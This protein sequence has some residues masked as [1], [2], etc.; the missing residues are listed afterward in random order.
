MSERI[1]PIQLRAY[2]D[3]QREHKGKPRPKLVNQ[4]LILDNETTT[5]TQRL[6]FGSAL[7]RTVQQ[8]D[9]GTIYRCFTVREVFYYADDLET[10]RPR[11]FKA[12]QRYVENHGAAI[13]Y[14]PPGQEWPTYEDQQHGRLDIET[15]D[16]I[17]LV[18]ESQ[19]RDSYILHSAHSDIPNDTRLWEPA[20]IVGANVSF[21]IWRH[22]NRVMPARGMFYGGL[23][24][25]LSDRV[26]YSEIRSGIGM[27]RRLTLSGQR[28]DSKRDVDAA[29]IVDVLQLTRA[30]TGQAH[31]LLSAGKAMGC[32]TLK[33][34][35][36]E[37]HD[38]EI[39]YHGDDL[40]AQLDHYVAYNRND[41]AATAELYEKV[42]DRFLRHPINLRADLTFSPASISKQY[43]RDMGIHAPLCA[44]PSCRRSNR[45]GHSIGRDVIGRCMTAFYGGKSCIWE[46]LT[47][48]PAALIDWTSM[49]P[50]IMLLCDI[51][52]MLIAEQVIVR[53]ATEAVQEFLDTVT[54]DDLDRPETW[55]KLRGI[56]EFL[57]DEDLG[58]T[59]A[60][61]AAI[62]HKDSESV[63]SATAPGIAVNYLTSDK[64]ITWTIADLVANKL[65]NG[66]KVPRLVN[67]W[68][69]EPSDEIQ[70]T[71]GPIKLSGED[72]LLFDPT[73]DNLLKFQIEERQKAKTRHKVNRDTCGHVW[74]EEDLKRNPAT[75]AVVGIRSCRCP[76]CE[77][78]A[79]AKNM[80]QTGYAEAEYVE[81]FRRESFEAHQFD[82][83]D[84][85]IWNADT[86]KCLCPDCVNASFLKPFSNS[87]Y[88]V[89]AEMNR[90][91]QRQDGKNRT[92]TIHGIDGESWTV[93]NP[94]EP[95]EFCFPPFA[96]VITGGAR[97]MLAMLEH[98]VRELG[99]FLVFCDTDSGCIPASKKGGTGVT[100]LSYAQ[101]DAIRE[102]FNQLNPYDRTIVE[103]LVKWEH[104]KDSNGRPSRNPKDQI[105][106][107]AIS[108]KRYALYSLVNNQ[109]KLIPDGIV[110]LDD[111]ETEFSEASEDD[112][113]SDDYV[114]DDIVKRS[115]HGLGLFMS[116]R[117][118][119]AHNDADVNDPGWYG[120]TWRYIIN[121]HVFHRSVKEP[122]WFSL[123]A[124]SRF[125]VR[126]LHYWRIFDQSFNQDKPIDRQVRPYNFYLA[127]HPVRSEDKVRLIAP[128]SD[129]P[130]TWLSLPWIDANTGRRYDITTDP[131]KEI[132]G[133][134][135]LVKDYRSVV[136]RYVTHPEWKFDAQDGNPCGPFTRGILQPAHVVAESFPHITKDSSS[137]TTAG[138]S[139]EHDGPHSF[140]DDGRQRAEAIA[141][142]ILCDK[143]GHGWP[144]I[145]ENASL[146]EREARGFTGNTVVSLKDDVS[147]KIISLAADIARQELDPFGYSVNRS[148]AT[149]LRAW[150]RATAK[151]MIP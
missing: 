117:V 129:D 26:N 35:G 144:W 64:P 94:E 141:R 136:F 116:P 95:G 21:D 58:P 125:P 70:S 27:R 44:C 113:N 23:S 69:F 149:I 16:R 40:D 100:L 120:E 63:K 57:P 78:L 20:T 93:V 2:P 112:S 128:F 17:E 14:G 122:K 97:L 3:H 65:L 121:K 45:G 7:L 142:E 42:M 82:K 137:L 132:P 126:T 109:P 131:D 4:A 55:R 80:V 146:T 11:T 38:P 12:L 9:D 74:P 135:I 89:F 75:G 147:R 83:Y 81:D 84:R 6:L 119:D 103:E 92:G 101:V 68:T 19:F 18:P 143:H 139:F 51:W 54:R 60:P 13:D 124:V 150:K 48:T 50:T 29:Y 79:W 1:L 108:A 53:Q 85:E 25:A 76:A 130:T 30:I 110:D 86:D 28:S 115:E 37:I 61:Y 138:D 33:Y 71:L 123:P 91:P 31:G 10:F 62:E 5:D 46:R 118:Q 72:A 102:R 148:P 52:E 104:P 24:G 88:G 34:D 39:N 107:T 140:A 151:G 90:H 96:A 41:V 114:A 134:V 127:A 98:D 66:G 43:L 87:I 111:A 105:Y 22:V 49:Y 36:I 32:K 8:N 133:K 77:R 56:A 106:V 145:S 99:S 67:A 47:S 73:Q 59:R 15:N